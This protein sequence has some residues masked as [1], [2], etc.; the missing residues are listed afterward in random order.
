MRG[1]G[2]G[3]CSGTVAMNLRGGTK[4]DCRH[5]SIPTLKS[6]MELR[7]SVESVVKSE[8]YFEGETKSP[9]Y[10]CA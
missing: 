8:S 7:K 3:K 1:N 9:L 4:G 5:V 6:V 10:R 2:D